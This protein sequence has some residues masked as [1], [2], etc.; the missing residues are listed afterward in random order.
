M[1]SAAIDVGSNTIRMLI[2][3]VDESGFRRIRSYRE[4]TRL[5]AGIGVSGILGQS[6]ME[7][8]ISVLK[9]FSSA[10]TACGAERVSAVG[11]SALRDARNGR[12]FVDAVFREAGIR[13][14][15]ISGMEEAELTAKGIQLGF[16]KRGV[17]LF[18]IDIGGGSTE[19]IILDPQQ[20]DGF[21]CGSLPVGV[22]SLSERFV[23]VEPPS[24][25]DMTALKSEIDSHISSLEKITGCIP[26]DAIFA[27]TGGTV[28]TLA[29]IDLGLKQYDPDQI[30]MRMISSGRLEELKELL[31]SLPL[32]R[33][34]AINGLDSGRADLI[35]PGILLTIK[36]MEFFGFREITVS[37]YGLLEGLLAGADE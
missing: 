30:H 25:G 11:T 6:S 28:T 22:V 31:F 9:G 4:I 26:S 1:R 19:W 35:I 8:S 5:A 18:V 37:D 33:R 24:S 23:N 20:D 36:F 7:K 32:E 14:R 3:D 17:P 29:S 2:G 10:A 12:E 16:Q 27:G 13:I 34:R 15:I 21:L